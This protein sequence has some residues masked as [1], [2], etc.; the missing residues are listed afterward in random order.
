MATDFFDF[1]EGIVTGKATVVP[2]FFDLESPQSEQTPVDDSL[3]QLF[4][5]TSLQ[6]SW[7]APHS[8]PELDIQASIWAG[9]TLHWGCWMMLNRADADVQLPVGL[10]TSEP[11]G[12]LASHHWSVDLLMVAWPSLLSRCKTDSPDDPLLNSLQNVAS[13]WPLAAVGIT[14]LQS[15]P[16]KR[17]KVV[18]QHPCLLQILVDR[19]I[20]FRAKTFAEHPV[21]E[22]Q[23]RQ[24]AGH[25]QQLLGKW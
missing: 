21:I 11:S 20:Q 5:S 25:Y 1:V 9:R 7:D 15:V 4:Q 2:E 14:E 12:E 13:R 22:K 17:M 18:L 3:R 10:K 8:A 19:V 23:I 16:T 6:R 24:A